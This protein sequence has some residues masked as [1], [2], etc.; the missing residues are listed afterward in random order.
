MRR[1]S[2]MAGVSRRTPAWAS[3]AAIAAR[4]VSG[5]NSQIPSAPQAR[6]CTAQIGPPGQGTSSCDHSAPRPSSPGTATPAAPSRSIARGPCTASRPRVGS[7]SGEAAKSS[8]MAYLLGACAVAVPC[9][10]ATTSRTSWASTN[11]RRSLTTWPFRLSSSD[12]LPPPTGVPT[13][14]PVRS[15]CRNAIRSPPVAR[16]TSR[17]PTSMTAESSN[18]T[19]GSSSSSML[20]FYSPPLAQAHGPALLGRGVAPAIL[21]ALQD[22]GLHV[23]GLAGVVDGHHGDVGPRGLV[24]LLGAQILDEDPDPD[25]HGGVGHEVHLGL[26]HHQRAQPHRAQEVDPVHGRGHHGGAGVAAGGDGRRQID[27]LEQDPAEDGPVHVGQAGQDDVGGLHAR[28]RRRAGRGRGVFHARGC[29][30]TRRSQGQT[31]RLRAPSQ[32]PMPSTITPRSLWTILVSLLLLALA[33]P[34]AA[35][36]Y[37]LDELLAMAKRSSPGMAASASQ[38]AQI[39]AQLSEAKRSWMP[40]GELVSLVAPVPEILCNPDTLN[41]ISTNHSEASL[42]LKGVFTRTEV[43]LV[44]PIYTFG[45]ISAGIDAA[46][47]GIAAS[48]SREAGVAAD[49][50]LNVRKAYWGAKLAREIMATIKDGMTYLDQAKS[51]VEKNLSTGTGNS[52]VVDR[53]RLDAM[54]ADVDGRVLEANKLLAIAFGGLRALLGPEAPADLDVDADPLEAPNVP[55]RPLSQ[56]EE[57][58]RLSRPEVQ[59]LNFL[60]NSKRALADLERRKQYPDVV[61]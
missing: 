36:P 39:E 51:Q 40:T 9:P 23:G 32:Q 11:T 60:V 27:P 3:R 33:R 61:L 48:R 25:L 55:Q 56:Y 54:R 58:A 21:V 16:M 7:G 6:A 15:R 38:T 10:A 50:E 47:A 24:A 34:A 22:Q 43:K 20:L 14:S 1:A 44:Q 2:A 12:R 57:Q 46:Q 28:G 18:S 30:N 29:G 35:R 13:T 4:A 53:H 5:A 45:K 8:M 52:T 19:R 37:K 42:N 26:D 17:A 41:C 31:C 59:A 49:V